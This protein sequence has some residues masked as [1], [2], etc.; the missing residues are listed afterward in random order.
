MK[1]RVINGCPAPDDMAPYYWLVLRRAHQQASSIYRGDDAKAILHRHGK[2]TQREIHA[3]MPA[4]S[5][6]AGQSQHELRSDGNA[7]DGP[8]GR[9]L[10]THRCGVDSGGNSE[11]D[12]EQIRKAAAHYGWKVE[13]PYSR[14]VEGH[15]WCFKERPTAR[16]RTMKLKI[17]AIR[18]G[19]PRR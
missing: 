18:A 13:H 11:H 1:F 17:R 4:I 7:D 9:H 5:N 19:L 14:G 10:P 16:S 15:H 2:H 6:P 3:S 8:V 12:K